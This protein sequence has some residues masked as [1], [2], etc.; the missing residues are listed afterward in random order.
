MVDAT[1]QKRKKKEKLTECEK[2]GI[3]AFLN[4][5]C[6]IN[7]SFRVICPDHQDNIQQVNGLGLWDFIYY[8]ILPSAKSKSCFIYEYAVESNVQHTLPSSFTP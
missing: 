7:V 6:G 2:V 3:N 8:I 5:L 4:T 1:L